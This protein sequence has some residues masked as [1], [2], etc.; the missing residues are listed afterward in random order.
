M[1]GGVYE[2]LLNAPRNLIIGPQIT[3]SCSDTVIRHP[4]VAYLFFTVQQ[5]VSQQNA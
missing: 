2:G 1:H 3:V 4:T 5:N